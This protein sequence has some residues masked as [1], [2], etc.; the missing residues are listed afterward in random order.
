M[1][2]TRVLIIG[3]GIAGPVLGLHLKLRGYEPIVYE[4]LRQF[5][6]LGVGLLYAV[7]SASH[8]QVLTC[9]QAPA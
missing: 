3:G 4:R 9:L 6:D 2:P 8:S 7:S 1:V 5:V